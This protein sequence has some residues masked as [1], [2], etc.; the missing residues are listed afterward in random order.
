[1]S[2]KCIAIFQVPVCIVGLYLCSSYIFAIPF[3]A[4]YLLL[5]FLGHL[6]PDAHILFSERTFSEF[7]FEI[8]FLLFMLGISI[9]VLTYAGWLLM[10]VLRKREDS[11]DQ[12]Y[13]ILAKRVW[14]AVNIAIHWTMD[15]Y[16][17]LFVPNRENHERGGKQAWTA[18]V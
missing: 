16:V 4:V 10:K 7:L 2:S 1:M 6:I 13:S 15:K 18:Q 5:R 9:E 11:G 12:K 3:A 8:W 17:R 14:W